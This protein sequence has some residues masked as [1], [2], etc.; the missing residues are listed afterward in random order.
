ME[1]E[2]P[3]TDNGNYE[4]GLLMSVKASVKGLRMSPRKV[5]VVA[6]LVRGRTVED[7]LTILEHTP[8]RSAKTV[9]KVI[10]SARANADHNHKL[11]PETL[12]LVSISVTPASRIKRY[13][14]GRGYRGGMDPY[15]LKSSHIFVEVDGEKRVPKK[16]TTKAT[17]DRSAANKSAA[18]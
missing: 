6:D 13:K 1:N 11:R 17:T 7:A 15:Q 2:K 14:K 4:G 12:R 5:G 10:E 16:S 18:M 3:R 8:R 9:K